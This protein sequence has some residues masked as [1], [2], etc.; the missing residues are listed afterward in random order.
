MVWL[1]DVLEIAT[2]CEVLVLCCQEVQ[3]CTEVSSSAIS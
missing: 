1:S 3:V 2:Y